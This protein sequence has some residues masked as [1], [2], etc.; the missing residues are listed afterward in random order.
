MK[1]TTFPYRGTLIPIGVSGVTHPWS[2]VNL[3]S[4]RDVVP[5]NDTFMNQYSE[6]IFEVLVVFGR[7]GTDVGEKLVPASRAGYDR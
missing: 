2:L 4:N 5:D 1:V 3:T 7:F 6:S